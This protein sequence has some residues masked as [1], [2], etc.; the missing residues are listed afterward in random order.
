MH[1]L[2]FQ[3]I[4]RD[5]EIARAIA[6][7]VHRHH[8]NETDTEKFLLKLKVPRAASIARISAALSS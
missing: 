2:Q 8:L 6:P 1:H 7:V 3:E 4:M 5:A